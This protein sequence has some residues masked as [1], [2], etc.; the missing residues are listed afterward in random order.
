MGCSEVECFNIDTGEYHVWDHYALC[1]RGLPDGY[2]ELE[3]ISKIDLV[4]E[5]RRLKG[6]S[7]IEKGNR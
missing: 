1:G 7:P 3:N 5:I 2:R 6:Q 4:N